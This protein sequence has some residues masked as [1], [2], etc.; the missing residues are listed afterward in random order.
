MTVGAHCQRP[1]THRDHAKGRR[2]TLVT[3]TPGCDQLNRTLEVLPG[4]LRV[5]AGCSLPGFVDNRV[6]GKPLPVAHLIGAE[7]TI[8]VVDQNRSLLLPHVLLAENTRLKNS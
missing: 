7:G 4:D 2:G 6:T 1:A 5:T 3:F 8:T